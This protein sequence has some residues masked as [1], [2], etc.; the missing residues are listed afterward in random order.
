MFSDS[1][2]RFPDET[3]RGPPLGISLRRIC[4]L[5]LAQNRSLSKG[6]NVADIS[7][8][9]HSSVKLIREAGKLIRQLRAAPGSKEI[10]I[11]V[12]GGSTSQEVV[13]LLEL[14]LLQKGLSPVL[15]QSEYGSYYEDAV[16]DCRQ[17][18]EFQP[19]LIYIHTGI[20]NIQN[21][22]AINA[23]SEGFSS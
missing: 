7:E 10:R 13:T 5:A 21:W 14:F 8:K 18:S 16:L 11:A 2:C 22:P 20:R 23:D 9:S 15:W 19:D 4:I 6:R 1:D 12:L 3:R 17:I